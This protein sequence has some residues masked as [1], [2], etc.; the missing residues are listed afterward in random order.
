MPFSPDQVMTQERY[1]ADILT[2]SQDV[3]DWAKVMHE[4]LCKLEGM[5][6]QIRMEQTHIRAD[7]ERIETSLEFIKREG[8]LS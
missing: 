5:V 3:W 2:T 8:R 7:L 6:Q 1:L 4:L